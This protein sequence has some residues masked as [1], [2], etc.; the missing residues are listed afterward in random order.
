M[1]LDGGSAIRSLVLLRKA[2]RESDRGIR[3][4]FEQDFSFERFHYFLFF[5]FF[6][7]V[8]ATI[9]YYRDIIAKC[10]AQYFKYHTLG[11]IQGHDMWQHAT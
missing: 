11:G 6:S 2:L 9:Y 3:I 5:F 10:A 8:I 7:P 4:D 1:L